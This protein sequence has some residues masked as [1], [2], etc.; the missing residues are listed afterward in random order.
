MMKLDDIALRVADV[1]GMELTDA[2]EP[3]VSQRYE[4]RSLH[5]K[6]EAIRSG[7]VT[8]GIVVRM[9]LDIAPGRAIGWRQIEDAEGNLEIRV[10]PHTIY[11]VK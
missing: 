11:R 4:M 7:E 9:L 3:L 5:V 6:S 10:Y 2:T 8:P 1:F